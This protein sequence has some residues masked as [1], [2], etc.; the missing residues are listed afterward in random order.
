MTWICNLAAGHTNGVNIRALL[1]K[2]FYNFDVA[3][4]RSHMQS[5]LVVVPYSGDG[6]RGESENYVLVNTQSVHIRPLLDEK[7]HNLNVATH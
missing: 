4:H 2:E 3:V 7:F 5:S 1:N 6:E